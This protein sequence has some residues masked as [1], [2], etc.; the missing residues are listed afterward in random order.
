[1]KRLSMFGLHKSPQSLLNAGIS[2][3]KANMIVVFATYIIHQP[4]RVVP[5]KHRHSTP[6]T[7]FCIPKKLAFDDILDFN[8]SL[9]HPPL[10]QQQQMPSMAH[11]Q[12]PPP[13]LKPFTAHRPTFPVPTSSSVDVNIVKQSS[14]SLSLHS[15]GSGQSKESHKSKHSQG[16][17][18][19]NSRRANHRVANRKQNA[20]NSIIQAP[21]EKLEDIDESFKSAK[22]TLHKKSMR[23]S[24]SY[25]SRLP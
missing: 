11:P 21:P 16:K 8:L 7:I 15:V 4:K 20:E 1:M 24:R 19:V 22:E 5:S 12:Q 25:D 6:K 9:F 13:P 2:D 18:S 10:Q 14:S 17:S 23:K 3:A